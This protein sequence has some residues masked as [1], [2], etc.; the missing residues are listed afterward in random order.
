[1]TRVG[2]RSTDL[3]KVAIPIPPLDEQ[4]DIADYLDEQTSRIDTLI[5]KQTQ[6]IDILRERRTATVRE[7]LERGL[8]G[9]VPAS[10]SAVEWLGSTPGGWATPRLSWVFRQIGSGTTPANE[11]QLEPDEGDVAWVT[12]GELRESTITS[13]AR[14]VSFETVA[15]LGALKVYPTG[16]LLIAMYGATI[17]RL[18]TLG[19]P[20]TVNQACCALAACRAG[21]ARFFEYV[22]LAARDHLVNLATGGGQ[23][24][25]SQET[26]R[27]LRVPSPPPIEQGEIVAYLDEQTSRI[28]ALIAKTQEHI[29][30]AKERRAALITAA[31]TGQIDVRTAAPVEMVVA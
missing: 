20:A 7:V 9:S 14:A 24:N 1:M 4:R 25:I 13:T 11:D 18:G 23:P 17:G 2:I 19:I 6:L 27:S 10:G 5:A 31:V 16:S 15:K 8:K 22:L 3:A 29:G 12:T 21:D 28:D 30:L 26:V